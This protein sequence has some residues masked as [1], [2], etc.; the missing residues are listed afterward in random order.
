MPSQPEN[1]LLQSE[2]EPTVINDIADLALGVGTIFCVR[3][4]SGPPM[5]K[6]IED[7]GIKAT[8][9]LAETISFSEE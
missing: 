3:L 7:Q 5:T 2:E 1:G 6:E 4:I 8:A 9:R